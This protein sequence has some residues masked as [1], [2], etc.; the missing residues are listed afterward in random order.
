LSNSET[1]STRLVVPVSTLRYTP[2]VY[3]RLFLTLGY[4]R[5]CIPVYSSP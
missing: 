1:G 4:T 2:G 5:V 3:T